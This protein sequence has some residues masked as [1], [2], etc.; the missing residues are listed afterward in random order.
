MVTLRVIRWEDLDGLLSFINSLVKEKQ[1]DSKSGLYAGF[2]KRVTREEEA[3]WLAQ[4]LV[5]IEGGVVINI[6][7]EIGGKIIANGEVTRGRYKDTRRHGHMGLTMISGY[8]GHGIGRVIIETLVRE[9]RRAGL[10]TLDVEFLAELPDDVAAKGR[11]LG[12]SNRPI[13]EK[14]VDCVS[15]IAHCHSFGISRVVYTTLVAK[16]PPLIQQKHMGRAN[17][18]IGSRNRPILILDVWKV[19][20]LLLNSQDH[21]SVGV[22]RRE[23]RVVRVESQ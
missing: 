18:P 2:D 21:F 23:I 10:R 20:T 11:C 14:I 4:S 13:C 9:S 22:S 15:Q 8:R 17:S 3:E 5:E 1:G 6:I 16:H 12:N 7:A 19:E